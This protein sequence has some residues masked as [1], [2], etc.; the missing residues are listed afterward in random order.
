M[1]YQFSTGSAGSDLLSRVAALLTKTVETA[2]KQRA[3]ALFFARRGLAPLRISAANA[4]WLAD[5]LRE[6]QRKQR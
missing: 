1:Y 5:N 2:V 6:K 4:V 3:V